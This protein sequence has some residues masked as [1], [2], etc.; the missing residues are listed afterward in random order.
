MPSARVVQVKPVTR[1]TTILTRT[2][3]TVTVMRVAGRVRGGGG[4]EA[5]EWWGR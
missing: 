1:R 3:M 4:G 5:G 2:V